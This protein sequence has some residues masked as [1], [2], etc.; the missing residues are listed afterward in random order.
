MPTSAPSAGTLLAVDLGLRMGLA[1]YSLEGRLLWHRSHNLGSMTRL[2][3]AVPSILAGCG[4]LQYIFLEG[5]LNLGAPFEREAA[6]RSIPVTHV[7]PEVWRGALLVPSRRETGRLA[8]AEAMRL[9]AG[10]I[11][12]I[13]V[14]GQRPPLK[15]DAAEAI[16]I[17]YFGLMTVGV[18]QGDSLPR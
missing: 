2:K 18:A 7:A 3:R 5:A 6:R 16:L 9:A 15:D 12:R 13:G 8:K 4:E 10:L 11:E 14:S 17:G 1:L